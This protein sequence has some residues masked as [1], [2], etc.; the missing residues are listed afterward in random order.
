VTTDRIRSLFFSSYSGLGGG[1]TSLL[2]LLGG[3]DKLNHA[4]AL[5][6]PQSGQLSAAASE[7]G[8]RTHLIPYR[9]ATSWFIPSLWRYLPTTLRFRRLLRSS[10]PDV[11]HSDYHSLP[12][13]LPTARSLGIP[14]IFTCWGWWFRPKP[15][16]RAWF[17]RPGLTILAASKAVARGS[18]AGAAAIAG[19]PA[20]IVYPGVDTH[21]FRPRRAQLSSLRARL[22]LAEE[23]RVVSLVA[24]YQHVKGHDVFLKAGRTIL[25][26]A[27]QV[28]LAIAGENVFGGSSEE[29]YKKKILSQVKGDPLLSQHLEFLGW[30]DRPQDLLAA[31]DV[32]V[33]PSRYESFGMVGVEA[34][35]C[36][37][38]VVSTNVGGPAETIVDGE[39]GFLV[40]PER[41]DMIAE[42]V[43]TLL[44][45]DGLRQRMGQ[46][47]RARVETHFSL[48]RYAAEFAGVVERLLAPHDGQGVSGQG[49]RR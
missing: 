34:M 6:C 20:A 1:E 5:V 33:V 23:G 8:I 2:A 47:G 25:E 45:D 10:R 7:L 32:V 26:S 40:P 30:I 16:Q 36:G 3:L 28:R 27:R 21:R 14:V 19:R 35:A 46:A 22:G 39:T 38:P 17:T 29:S 42:R 24:R 41:P 44:A 13:V 18:L 37:V 4:P 49:D 31:S 11:V 12:Y 9:G 48:D 15:W 43:L